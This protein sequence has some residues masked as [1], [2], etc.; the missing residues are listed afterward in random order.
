MSI[1]PI[2]A[3]VG[4]ESMQTRVNVEPVTHVIGVGVGLVTH[5]FVGARGVAGVCGYARVLVRV[6]VV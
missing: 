6:R 3:L 1:A 5:H 2:C 4:V